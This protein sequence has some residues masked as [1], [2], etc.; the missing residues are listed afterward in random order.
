MTG[1]PARILTIGLLMAV[2]LSLWLENAT[3]QVSDS[4]LQDIRDAVQAAKLD[5]SL[6]EGIVDGTP[7]VL[8]KELPTLIQID[9]HLHSLPLE[10]QWQA[11][12]AHWKKRRSE[13]SDIEANPNAPFPLFD[14]V[15]THPNRHRGQLVLVRGHVLRVSALPSQDIEKEAA[16]EW[17]RLDVVPFGEDEQARI[18][19]ICRDIPVGLSLKDDLNEAISAV[20]YFFKLAGDPESSEARRLDPVIIARSVDLHKVDLPPD[21]LSDVKDRTAFPRTG[22]REAYLRLLSH[23]QLVD[24]ATQRKAAAAFRRQRIQEAKPKLDPK[25]IPDFVDMYVDLFKNPAVYR[26]QPVELRGYARRIIG[27]PAG[28][29]EFGIDQLYE[30]ALY[31]DK[32]QTRP[33]I[34]V[35]TDIPD[36]LKQELRKRK[37]A[38]LDEPIHGISVTGYLFKF[39]FYSTHVDR[40]PAPIL[41]AQR[42]TWNPP[43][44]LPEFVIPPWAYALIAVIAGGMVV[45]FVRSRRKDREFQ[46]TLRGNDSGSAEPDLSGLTV[47]DAPGI[48]AF[49][50]EFNKTSPVVEEE[51]DQSSET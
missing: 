44:P 13:L 8:P 23:V 2:T 16:E 47:D 45:L 4:T 18:V 35:C 29:N 36:A 49:A 3:A 19:L 50:A 34:V 32:S 26:G 41:V 33:A 15:R 38:N 30:I 14:D 24:Y 48:G 27:T 43:V 12:R 31:T 10:Q 9:W 42:L 37:G 46:R 51:S 1:P 21:L 20:G 6:I 25:K 17:Y 28:K 22:D 7:A 40:E 39:G 5:P 11:Y